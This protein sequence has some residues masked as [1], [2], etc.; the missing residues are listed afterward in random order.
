MDA[1]TKKIER[2]LIADNQGR[3]PNLQELKA[4]VRAANG[5]NLPR[6]WYSRN[7]RFTYA[8]VEDRDGNIIERIPLHHDSPARVAS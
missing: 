7:V 6:G 8:L 4:A 5:G 1:F 2:Q 3:E